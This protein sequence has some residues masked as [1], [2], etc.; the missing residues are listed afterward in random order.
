MINNNNDNK[1]NN[2]NNIF[3]LN[4]NDDDNNKYR[5]KYKYDNM[6]LGRTLAHANT[7]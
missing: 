5:V 2:N 4:D 6:C 1:N 7:C 3:F